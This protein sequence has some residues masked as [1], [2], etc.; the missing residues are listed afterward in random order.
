MTR[1]SPPTLSDLEYFS[2]IPEF[3]LGDFAVNALKQATTLFEVYSCLDTYPEAG[4]V[5]YDIAVNGICDMALALTLSQPHLSA[6][7]G[8]YQSESIGSYSY[9]KVSS[10]VQK[11]LPTDVGWFD[12]AIS[13]LGVCDS[14][15][16]VYSDATTIFENDNVVRD[17]T[18]RRHVI[19]PRDIDQS[20]NQGW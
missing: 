8:P 11:G 12:R 19:G 10:L 6:K 18:G 13:E 7:Y 14:G 9:S 16:G 3:E 2:G 15:A 4:S 17:V 1:L 20:S 5:Q